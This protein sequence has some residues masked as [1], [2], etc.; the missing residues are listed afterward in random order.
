MIRK[1]EKK[2]MSARGGLLLAILLILVYLFYALTHYTFNPFANWRISNKDGERITLTPKTEE[3]TKKSRKEDNKSHLFRPSSTAKRILYVSLHGNLVV[4]KE[5]TETGSLR[6]ERQEKY[7]TLQEFQKRFVE[8]PKYKKA[9]FT[10]YL[11]GDE[12]Y[13]IYEKMVLLLGPK[14][15]QL[16]KRGLPYF[17][18]VWKD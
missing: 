2:L 8:N 13:G 6:K 17:K 10:L 16:D 11:T 12:R 1:K 15:Y 7:F 4:V 9:Y 14:K 18:E 3:N 5:I